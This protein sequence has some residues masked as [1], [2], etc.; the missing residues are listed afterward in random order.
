MLGHIILC[1]SRIGVSTEIIDHFRH[2][3]LMIHHC[4]MFFFVAVCSAMHKMYIFTMTY[5]CVDLP[6]PAFTLYK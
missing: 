1:F 4:P 3:D 5:F 6:I 2:D